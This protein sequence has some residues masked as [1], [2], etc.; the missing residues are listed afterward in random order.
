MQDDD[1]HWWHLAICQ[2]M[3]DRAQNEAPHKHVDV[4]FEGYED[5][6]VLAKTMDSICN[7][8]PVQKL[9]LK[10]GIEKGE[11]GLWGGVFLLNGKMDKS[12]NG[13]KTDEDWTHIRELL[14]S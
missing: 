12:K 7:S 5:D 6:P 9:C 4:F 10:E 2:G 13:H 1:I 3:N 8:C 14:T 11:T